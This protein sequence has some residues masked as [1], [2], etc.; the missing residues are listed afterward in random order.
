MPGR[1]FAGSPTATSEENELAARLRDHVEALAESPDRAGIGERNLLRRPEALARAAQELETR[2]ATSGRSVTRERFTIGDGP[3]A[4]ENVVLT[5]PGTTRADEL[6]VVGAHYDTA[7]GSPG[8]N[9][10]ASGCS[11]LIELAQRCANRAH[12]RTLRFVAFANEEP[13]FFATDDMGSVANARGSRERG[14][15]VVAML[16]LET[17]GCYDDRPGSQRYPIGA[18]SWIYPDRGDFVAFVGNRGS[19]ALVRRCIGTFREHARIASEGAALFESIPG[20]GWS[21]HRSFWAEGFP[22]LMVT[23]TAIFRDGN[24]HE[25]SDTPEKLDYVRF[26]RVVLGLERVIEDLL[27]R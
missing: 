17:L 27:E 26:A 22:A 6:V 21:D 5:L 4:A 24:Y 8:A 18:L 11:A 25:A 14:E 9:D 7:E 13:P 2:L 10:N 23:D 20:V 1:S 15:N 12:A 16:S 3:L 19:R